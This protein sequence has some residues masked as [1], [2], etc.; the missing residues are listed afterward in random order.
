MPATSAAPAGR[1]SGKFRAGVRP[2]SA[3]GFGRR[4]LGGGPGASA[5]EKDGGG[6]RIMDI[7]STKSMSMTAA[8]SRAMSEQHKQ[9]RATRNLA[10]KKQIKCREISI[11]SSDFMLA[12]T[13]APGPLLQS[14]PADDSLAIAARSPSAPTWRF[15]GEKE[16]K[17]PS[18]EFEAAGPGVEKI[19]GRGGPTVHLWCGGGRY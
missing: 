10:L 4:A 17:S 2:H 14:L 3:G 1:R 15:R 18:H 19:H 6:G 12:W 16:I 7:R 13:Y 9:S 5:A 8:S 11:G